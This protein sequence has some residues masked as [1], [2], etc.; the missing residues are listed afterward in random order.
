V[1]A[2]PPAQRSSRTF[3][4]VADCNRKCTWLS[5]KASSSV[6]KGPWGIGCIDFTCGDRVGCQPDRL[7]LRPKLL[8]A[9]D[10]RR[11]KP[12]GAHLLFAIQDVI[13]LEFAER[14]IAAQAV[15]GDY[16]PVLQ[17]DVGGFLEES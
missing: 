4:C 9:N 7:R 8:P 17:G 10:S 15:D 2:Q 14:F 16:L 11:G 5:L 13:D 1:K 12:A 6:G 3:G